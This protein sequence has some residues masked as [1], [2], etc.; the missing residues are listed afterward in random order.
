MVTMRIERPVVWSLLALLVWLSGCAAIRAARARNTHLQRA[1]QQYVYDQPCD[2]VWPAARRVLFEAGYAVESSER[3][4]STI[5]TEWKFHESSR[6]RYL[7]QGMEP[8]S[9]KCRVRFERME[10]DEDGYTSTSRDWE[11]EWRV[12]QQVAPRAAAEIQQTANQ[13]AARAKSQ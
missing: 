10:E 12:L 2:Q 5:E 4:S 3:M 13:K 9:G 6:S 1:T 7:V 8:A 11:M